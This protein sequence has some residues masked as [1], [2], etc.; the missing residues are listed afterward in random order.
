MHISTP[1]GENLVLKFDKSEAVY[2]KV[3]DDDVNNCLEKY[4]H[5]Y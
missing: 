3:T 4:R 5:V 2:F 1:Y